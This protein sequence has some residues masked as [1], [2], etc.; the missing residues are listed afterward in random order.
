MKMEKKKKTNK[1]RK[2][3]GKCPISRKLRKKNEIFE[4]EVFI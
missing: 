1:R 2:K 3:C 4:R